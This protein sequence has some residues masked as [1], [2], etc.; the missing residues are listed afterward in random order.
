MTRGEL[1]ALLEDHTPWVES[2]PFGYTG[3]SCYCGHD[4]WNS[5]HLAD[6]LTPLLEEP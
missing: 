3:M 6:V 1:I 5:D 4:K 2:N